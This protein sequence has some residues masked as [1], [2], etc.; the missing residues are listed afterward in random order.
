MLI[1]MFAKCN[2]HDLYIPGFPALIE[3]FYV[4]EKLMNIYAHKISN[5]FVS[6]VS[7]VSIV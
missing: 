1:K 3:S 2:L 4:Q 6:I 5:H 7:I